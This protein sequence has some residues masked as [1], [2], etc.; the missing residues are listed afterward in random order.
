MSFY[1]P[2]DSLLSGHEKSL[3]ERARAFCDHAFSSSL[4]EC[5]LQGKPFDT[6][7]IDRWAEQ[8]FLGLQA[9]RYDG[10]EEASFLCKIRVAQTVAE[11]GFGVAFALNNLQGSVTKLSRSGTVQQKDQ[12]LARL[13]SGQVLSAS[14]MSEP[15]GGSDLGA[16]KTNARR[17]RQGW[18]INGSKA[19][20][21]NGML[22]GCVSLLA[23]V[24][25]PDGT[26][27]I[28][29]FLVPLVDGA[30]LTREEIVMP[31]ARS[32]R[33]A[34]LTFVDYPAPAWSP[35]SEAGQGMRSSM[36]SVNAARVHVAAM[37][38]ASAKSALSD[39]V[40]YASQRESFGHAV[41]SHQGMNW[42]LAEI[43]TRLEAASALVFQAALAIHEGGPS[44]TIAAQAKSFAVRTA[45]WAIE[46]AQSAMGAIGASASHRL[47]MLLSEVRL[48]SYADGT[49]EMLLNRIG[50]G[51]VKEYAEPAGVQ[52]KSEA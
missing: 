11:H 25:Q 27:G 45:C 40:R 30:S 18:V 3:V 43:S 7:W 47:A 6:E 23:R 8:G 5:F 31:G 41:L 36:A 14:A 44:Q 48:A 21:T 32:F 20:V 12:L 39:A 4:L 22:V 34:T 17:T 52:R 33:L 19:W 24:E 1:A 10:G 37:C 16:L 28:G 49:N 9:L 26:S 13:R 29:S 38:V 42:Q 35:F 46:Q 50:K 51:L 15:D 2:Y